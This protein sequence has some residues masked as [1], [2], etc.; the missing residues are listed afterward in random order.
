VTVVEGDSVQESR[1]NRQNVAIQVIILTLY[2]LCIT[3]FL[4]QWPQT[5]F[6]EHSG[7]T[8]HNCED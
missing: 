8:P 6:S 2:F 5:E 1:S 7:A 3:N 4:G